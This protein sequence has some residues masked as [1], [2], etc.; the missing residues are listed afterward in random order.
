MP[1]HTRGGKM[2]AYSRTRYNVK[3]VSCI[4]NPAPITTVI[5]HF[6]PDQ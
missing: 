2:S 1:V 5:F 6:Y 4:F 3:Y